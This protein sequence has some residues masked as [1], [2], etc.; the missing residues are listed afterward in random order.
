MNF[1]D[2]NVHL[3]PDGTLKTS[4]YKKPTDRN[5]YLH[6]L[7]YHTPKQISNIPYGQFLRVKKICSELEDAASAINELEK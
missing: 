5:A 7:S 6:Y 2:T 1:L 4:L 3:N